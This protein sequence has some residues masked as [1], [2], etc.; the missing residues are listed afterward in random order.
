M[1]EKIVVSAESQKV[2]KTD[3]RCKHLTYIFVYIYIG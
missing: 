2:R 3:I 1:P